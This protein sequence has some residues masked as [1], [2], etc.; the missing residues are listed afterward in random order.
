MRGLL[1]NGEKSLRLEIV[2]KPDKIITNTIDNCAVQLA[3]VQFSHCAK[4]VILTRK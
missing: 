4:K 1:T 2:I 3:R